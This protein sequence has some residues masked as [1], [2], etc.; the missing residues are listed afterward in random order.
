MSGV[1]LVSLLGDTINMK[2]YE[3]EV[4]ATEKGKSPFQDWLDGIKD[5]KARRKLNAKL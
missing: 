1:D 3:I 4:Y 2:R 5:E